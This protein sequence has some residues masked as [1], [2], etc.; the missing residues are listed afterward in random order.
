VISIQNAGVLEILACFILINKMHSQLT[1]FMI[2]AYVRRY[3]VTV[4]IVLGKIKITIINILLIK[5]QFTI[6]FF[7]FI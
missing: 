1:H 7:Y 5:N 3:L 4:E 2:N 6:I